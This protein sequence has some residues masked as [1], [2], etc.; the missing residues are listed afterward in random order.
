[1]RRFL[2]KLGLRLSNVGWIRNAIDQ[3]ADLSEFQK[4]PTVRIFAGIFLICVSFCIGWPIIGVMAG[5][6]V[7]YH[8]AFIALFGPVL[9][10]LSHVLY[11]TGMWLSGEKY[12]RIFTRWSIRRLVE[13]LL[14]FGPVPTATDQ[15]NCDTARESRA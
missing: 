4:R 1:V 8:H 15:R 2:Y 6:A 9:Y 3:Q 5:A 10:G 11:L 7:Y 14:S 12:V 13:R